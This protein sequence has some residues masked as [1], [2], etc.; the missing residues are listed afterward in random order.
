MRGET[1]ALAA[2]R[3]LDHLYQQLLTFAQQFGDGFDAAF[4]RG[5]VIIRNRWPT[6]EAC[7]NA[8]RS[9]PMSTKAACMPGSTRLTR[10][11]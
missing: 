2:E 1:R 11:L 9:R 4:D 5:V 7:R 6:S 10:P 3:V 8:A